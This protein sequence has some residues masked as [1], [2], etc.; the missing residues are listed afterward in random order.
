MTNTIYDP[1]RN[2]LI[3]SACVALL[4]H[5]RTGM[6]KGLTKSGPDIF[7]E[8]ILPLESTKSKRYRKSTRDPDVEV[9]YS[10]ITKII[11]R[12]DLEN[13]C[14]IMCLAFVER[15]MVFNQ[16]DLLPSNWRR[17]VM[18]SFMIAAKV[19]YDEVV[20]N[21][22][23]VSSFP[24]YDLSNLHL[25][26]ICMLEMIDYNVIVHQGLYAKYYFELRSIS[27]EQ[28]FCNLRKKH[29]LYQ[30]EGWETARKK[31]S[32]QA[33]SLITTKS[34]SKMTL[35]VLATPRDHHKDNRRGSVPPLS[36][37]LV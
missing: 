1:D 5:I 23:F 15:I 6:E 2:E 28:N 18:T 14:I 31:A 27:E 19:F 29:S 13:T 4:S 8:E 17:V 7:N 32:A 26:E 12:I 11:D 9:L 36:S 21:A 24:N 10:F 37:T 35:S 30:V 3:F 34:S 20:W 16:F 33:D 25:M 22:D